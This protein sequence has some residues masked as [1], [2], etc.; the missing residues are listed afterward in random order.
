LINQIQLIRSFIQTVVNS[1]EK[2]A[3][4]V[5]D[6]KSFVKDQKNFGVSK[7]NLNSNISSVLNIFNYEIHRKCSLKF[8][9]SHDLFVHGYEIKLFQLWSNI[10]KNAIEAIEDSGKS[11][12]IYIYSEEFIDKIRVVFQNNGPK[13][14]EEVIS[15]IFS[16]FYTTKAHKNGS[17][18][19]LSIAM[20][21]I[22][23]HKASI[24]IKSNDT[25]TEFLIDFPKID[26]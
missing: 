15:K 13:I 19:G 18:I 14:P 25:Q 23:E 4:I 26:W 20:N 21:I 5:Q 7:I 24:S 2:A 22:E 10:I 16:K 8:E 6:M 1:G 17:G 11:G 12:E 3:K 9:V